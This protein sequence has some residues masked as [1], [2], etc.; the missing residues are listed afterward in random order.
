MSRALGL[1]LAAKAVHTGVV[2]GVRRRPYSYPPEV[3]RWRVFGDRFY[4]S[5]KIN[6]ADI[7]PLLW[8]AY[9]GAR[10]AA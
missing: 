2:C 10:D 8:A 7:T 5:V 1:L 6:G 3:R 4:V 9:K